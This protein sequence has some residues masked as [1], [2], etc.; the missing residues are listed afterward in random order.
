MKLLRKYLPYCICFAFFAAYATLSVVRHNHY[1]SFGFDLGMIDQVVWKYSQ[2]K[3][4]LNTV[5]QFPF[6][7]TF[8]DHIEFIY[9]LIAPFY[10][11]FSDA[12]I[13]LI[14]QAFAV[15]FSGIP[16]FLFA[17]RKKLHP[18]LC[19]ALLIS[20]LL[21]YGIQNALWFDIH[22]LSFAAALLPW[23]LYFLDKGNNPLTFL[24]F[25]LAI[26]TKE[27][28]ALFTFII[29]FIYFIKTRSK[30][31][32]ALMAISVV[33]LML[34]FFIYFPYFTHDGYRF[35]NKGGMFSEL[36]LSYFLDTQDKQKVIFYGLAWFGFFPI[37]APLY[38]LPAFA[39]LSHYFILGHDVPTAQ[40]FF[41]H[42][43]VT[44]AL[45]LI[46]PTIIIISY[47][48]K[49]LNNK[50]VAVYILISALA[51]QYLLHLPLSYLTKKWFWQQPSSVTAVNSVISFIPSNAS[52]VSQ[53]NIT[54]HISHRPEIFTLWPEQKTFQKASPCDK[55]TC[56]WFR[57]S[58]SPQYLIADISPEWDIRHFLAQRDNFINGL[59]NME[60]AKII[61]EVKTNDTAVL[62]KILKKP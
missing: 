44:L 32:I 40:T 20:Y 6:T 13:L 38:L 33:Y 26:G 56:D 50:Y 28:I 43:R 16:V 45:F 47:F 22:S 34:I 10:W 61:K 3:E 29:S 18:L 19:Y 31:T 46:W 30:I 17:K 39:D 53:N 9:L 57:W 62:Y 25:F 12:R 36:N 24:F 59:H 4:P 52:V 14:L 60:K 55:N 1:G 49:Y 35:R 2:F 42:Y 5:Y 23:F 51:F 58:G 41:M 8:T 21:F 15:T 7:S 37:L 27:D 11:I 48:K 54:P